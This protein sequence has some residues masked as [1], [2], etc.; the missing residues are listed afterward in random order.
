MKATNKKN[1]TNPYSLL[2]LVAQGRTSNPERT[3]TS[4]TE[5]EKKGS[6]EGRKRDIQDKRLAVPPPPTKPTRMRCHS[7]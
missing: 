5:Y 2:G 1:Q 4:R 3:E 7:R 6:P